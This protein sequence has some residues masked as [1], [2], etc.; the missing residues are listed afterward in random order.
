MDAHTAEPQQPYL[1][2]LRAG[3]GQREIAASSFE[4]AA[5]GYL[6]AAHPPA[7]EDGELAV[8]V[9]E[10]DSGREQCFRVDLAG[11]GAE[12]CD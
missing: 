12:P 5:L 8:I 4:E 3:G 2:R 1:V 11:G 10:R 7:D 9:R 6:E